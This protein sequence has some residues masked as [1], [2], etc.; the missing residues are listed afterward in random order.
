M[1]MILSRKEIKEVRAELKSRNKKVVFTNGCFDLIH[2]GH[3]DY[4]VKAKQL[5][6]VL[7]VGLNTDESV[8]R[9]KGEKRPILKQDERAFI[10]SNLKPVDYVTFFDEDTP[11]EIISDLIP[12]ILVKGADWSIDKIVGREVVEANGGEVKTIEFVNDQS[13]SKIIQTI[14]SRYK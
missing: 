10:V 11:A 3:V 13:T 2:S 9:I 12:D 7:I 6:D 14:L 5:G 8:R 4:L 1:K